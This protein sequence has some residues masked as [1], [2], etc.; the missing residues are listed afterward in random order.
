[1]SESTSL[2]E[3]YRK[4]ENCRRCP[5]YKT[6]KHAVPGEGKSSAK[7]MFI[8]EAPGRNE[9]E[10]G[11]PFVG[12][13]GKLL[14]ELLNSIGIARESV[15]ITSVIKHRPPNNRQPKTPEI[16]ACSFF[17][18]LQIKIINPRLIVTL[19]RFGMEYFLPEEKISEIHGKIINKVKKDGM[20][21]SIFPVY[22]PAAGLR[23]TRNK[24][25]LF[26]DFRKLK[27]IINDIV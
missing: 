21:L 17:L 27:K 1:M 2:I 18:K 5:L 19:G 20:M 10:T 24:E 6:A 25:K 15:F 7:I 23:S 4:I 22:H 12:R 14:D 13:A 11:R 16:K 3:L 9:D 8:G 26:E